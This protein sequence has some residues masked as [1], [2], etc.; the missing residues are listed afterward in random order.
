[1]Q[2]HPPLVSGGCAPVRWVSPK[3]QS[4]L[5]QVHPP[6]GSELWELLHG[7]QRLISLKYQTYTSTHPFDTLITGMT[8]S[9]S[10]RGNLKETTWHRL[11]TITKTFGHQ[12]GQVGDRFGKNLRRLWN[13]LETSLGQTW[14]NFEA[15]ERQH[16]DNFWRTFRQLW[17]NFEP[18]MSYSDQMTYQMLPWDPLDAPLTSWDPLGVHRCP[19]RPPDQTRKRQVG[20]LHF[21]TVYPLVLFEACYIVHFISR[22]V[23][24]QF[25]LVCILILFKVWRAADMRTATLLAKGNSKGCFLI[26]GVSFKLPHRSRA[27]IRYQQEKTIEE[28]WTLL[29]TFYLLKTTITFFQV[30]KLLYTMYQAHKSRSRFFQLPLGQHSA[31]FLSN[32]GKYYWYIFPNMGT[33]GAVWPLV[34]SSLIGLF[35]EKNI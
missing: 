30:T 13:N 31:S 33:S 2:E 22:I 18:K 15:Y 3:V 21:W 28:T 27:G 26:K 23:L 6:R 14:D 17:D 8:H 16:W 32:H 7:G 19:T 9:A 24:G 25:V 20:R 34:N 29:F 5:E 11:G 4:P 1:M 35:R 10:S 12:L